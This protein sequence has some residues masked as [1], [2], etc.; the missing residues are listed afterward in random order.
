VEP[1]QKLFAGR[2]Q[3]VNGD[4]PS[5]TTPGGRGFKLSG[6]AG[7][8]NELESNIAAER[9][10]L[11]PPVTMKARVIYRH[12]TMLRRCVVFPLKQSPRIST[13]NQNI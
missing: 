5:D 6:A 8:Q 9:V 10:H 3:F 2:E 7:H 13:V 12:R 1:E 11:L 4:M